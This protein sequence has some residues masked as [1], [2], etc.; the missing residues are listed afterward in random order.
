MTASKGFILQIIIHL[1]KAQIICAV[2]FV[3]RVE[4]EVLL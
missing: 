1:T 3:A 2:M 4:A